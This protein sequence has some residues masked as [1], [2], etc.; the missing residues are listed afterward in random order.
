MP[1][2]QGLS[3]ACLGGALLSGGSPKPPN[4]P[5]TSGT[6]RFLY[7]KKKCGLYP[8]APEVNY[9]RYAYK[10]CGVSNR[11]VPPKSCEY[12]NLKK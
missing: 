6:R 8:L 10:N 12:W 3:A 5:E 9:P 7:K 11:G 2:P 1:R 4:P